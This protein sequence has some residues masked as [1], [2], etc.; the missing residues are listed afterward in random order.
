MFSALQD[1]NYPNMLKLMDNVATE[2]MITEFEHERATSAESFL[3]RVI[4]KR[5]GWRRIGIRRLRRFCVN[6]KAEEVMIVTGSL[7]FLMQAREYLLKK[8]LTNKI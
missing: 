5:N 4:M 6:M 1:K 7:Y 3:S 2:I 8:I